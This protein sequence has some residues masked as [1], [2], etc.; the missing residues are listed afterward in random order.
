MVG[1]FLLPFGGQIVINNKKI[2]GKIKTQQIYAQE[3]DPN[4]VNWNFSSGA[5]ATLGF[6]GPYTLSE[7]QTQQTAYML[8]NPKASVGA[9]KFA[10]NNLYSQ[11]GNV[12]PPPTE[13]E[14]PR[15]GC[16]TIAPFLTITK[17]VNA[18]LFYVIFKPLAWLM[19]VSGE[20]LDYF[21]FYSTSDQ[22]YRSGFIGKAWGAIRDI[23]NI[24]F[25]IALLFIA[26]KTVL[27]I[28]VSNNK[29]L[30]GWVIV[31]ALL[32]NFSLF[33]TQVVVDASNILARVFYNE[34]TAKGK[35]GAVVGANKEKSISVAL[36]SIFNPQHI[37]D[38][39]EPKD[40]PGGYLIIVIM[41]I[42]V[43]AITIYVF[44][45]V[46]F[47][48]VARVIGLWIAMIFSPLAFASKTVSF[49]IPGFGW[50]EWLTNTIKY[51]FMAPIFIF[52][53]YVIVLLADSLKGLVSF[54]SQQNDVWMT[55]FMNVLI[56]FILISVLLLKARKLAVEYSGEIG[57]G[58]MTAVKMGGGLVGGAAL[59]AAAFGGS[60]LV[61]GV[62][63]R[64]LNKNGE[65]LREKAKEGGMSGYLARMQLKTLNYG[66]K[67]TFD[68]RQTL[69]GNQ[70]SKL[71][72]MNFQSFKPLGS[73]AGGY[74]GM[75]ERKTEKITKESELYKTKMSDTEVQKWSEE[76]EFKYY[77]ERDEAK[78]NNTLDAFEKSRGKEPPKKYTSANELNH[79]RMKAFQDNIGHS[80]LLGSMI[81]STVKTVNKENYKESEEYKTTHK[82]EEYETAKRADIVA[83]GKSG[84]DQTWDEKAFEERFNNE[85][86]A[87][88]FGAG[89]ELN[90]NEDIAKKIN[91]KRVQEAKV[92]IGATVGALAGGG[93][94]AG[95][96]GLAGGIA[97]SQAGG[98]G[99]ALLG[100]NDQVATDAAK[101][102]GSA[103]AKEEKRMK[104]VQDRINDYDKVL[105]EH[106]A[107]VNKMADDKDLA[108]I[109]IV[110]RDGDKNPIKDA[111][112]NVTNFTRID[113]E[114]LAE[115][116]AQNDIDIKTLDKSL[117]VKTKQ[118]AE[119]EAKSFGAGDM[120]TSSKV[121]VIKKEIENITTEIK[122]KT[123]QNSKLNNIKNIKESMTEINNKVYGLKKDTHSTSKDKKVSAT[124]VN[125]ATPSA[126]TKAPHSDSGSHDTDSHGGDDHGGG[127][128]SHD[129]HDDGHH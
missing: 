107:S 88:H 91:K 63:S 40:D 123:I 69:A 118:I 10:K 7:C 73:K 78:K 116:I 72:G 61:G 109:I 29:K 84:S 94:G 1:I 59:G 98:V 54:S 100:L 42:I 82:K 36:V 45:S 32:I 74:T 38:G 41:A 117:D 3:E 2:T 93:L 96:F 83:H 128:E 52:F 124:K 119:L 76:Q 126:E 81:Y 68:A 12:A 56:P 70:L 47:L 33:A 71:S 66:T 95:A 105:K 58:V 122:T 37:I 31:I 53:L 60:K 65:A 125:V 99:G 25:I 77:K 14:D 103:L 51:A 87:K 89:K 106:Q 111:S 20:L 80:G 48:F 8:A 6:H 86:Q 26:L 4:A 50:N 34:I 23:S 35:N 44:V 30:V 92:I 101:K 27:S 104:D 55:S 113:K 17:C 15:F 57:A 24:F 67:A 9:C 121:N 114:K 19:T 129:A 85:Y 13:K 28:N 5:G 120:T 11:A 115:K 39:E 21:L 46:A 79:D 110:D 43:V 102:F 62:A 75:V 49:K 22:A 64:L 97:G 18:L 16:W 112:G 127:G 90:F 108:D